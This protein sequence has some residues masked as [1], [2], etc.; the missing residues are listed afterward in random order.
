MYKLR[1]IG[2]TISWLKLCHL[3]EKFFNY[4][5]KN[6]KN[7]HQ[8][9]QLGMH[10]FINKVEIIIHYVLQEESNVLMIWIGNTIKIPFFFFFFQQSSGYFLLSE[11]MHGLKHWVIFFF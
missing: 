11:S 1:D 7:C 9:K 5:A 10:E 2:I 6:K 3:S 4:E 8:V